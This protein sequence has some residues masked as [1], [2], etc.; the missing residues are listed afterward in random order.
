MPRGPPGPGV[1]KLAVSPLRRVLVLC[2]GNPA[3][4]DDGIGPMVALR[5]QELD[6]PGVEVDSDYQLTVEDAAAVAEHDAVVFVDAAVDGPEP[7]SWTRVEPVA[8]DAFSTHALTAGRVVG[9]AR[10][11]F[12]SR[13]EAYQLGV[14]GYSF[15]M[16]REEPTARAV[17]NARLA[18]RF[19]ARRIGAGLDGAPSVHG[20]AETE[21]GRP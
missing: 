2:Y 20:A 4:E 11:L 8:D 21:R 7:F 15:G 1:G 9:L 13:G 6:L 5:I 16:F 10:E 17:R 18:S 14:R 12:G 19:L 3:R